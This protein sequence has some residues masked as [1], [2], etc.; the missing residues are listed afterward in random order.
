MKI[1]RYF[2]VGGVA[3]VVDISIFT[4]F[5]KIVGF[6]Y[7]IVGFFS[8]LIA[9]AVNYSLSIRHVFESGAK[10]S[11]KKEIFLVYTVSAI[12]L[13]MNLFV[14]YLSV[15]ICGLEMIFSKI[16]ATAVVFFWNYFMRRFYV[17]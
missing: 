2:F 15:D 12:G 16:L 14:L 9:T 17:F 4:V 8:F 1:V 13:A 11:K 6:N 10:H 7:L 3:F 5:A